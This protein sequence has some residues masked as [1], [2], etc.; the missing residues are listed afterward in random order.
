MDA[1]QGILPDSWLA[2]LTAA[3]TI[4]AAVTVV[5]P[6]PKDDSGAVYRAVYRVIQ[7]IALNLGR[8]KN[9]EDPATQKTVPTTAGGASGSERIAR[10]A[11]EN[12]LAGFASGTRPA[13]DKDGKR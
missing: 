1:L 5:L 7:W 11:G 6:A 9:A 8:A 2:W 10:A 3:V 4:C 13:R 12:G